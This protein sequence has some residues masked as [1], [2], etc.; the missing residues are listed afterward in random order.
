MKKIIDYFH[1]DK[2]GGFE[3][4]FAFFPILSQYNFGKVYF[5][6]IFLLI[7]DFI[8]LAK[9]RKPYMF[10]PLLL[11]LVFYIIHEIPILI[12]FGGNVFGFLQ[13]L[14]TIAS[15]FFIVP[16]LRMEKLL[17][18]IYLVAL[19]SMGGL[20]YHAAL[21]LSGN[22]G[23]LHPLTLPFLPSFDAESRA[24]EIILRPTSFY[25]EPS[26][27]IT[28]MLIPMLFSLLEKKY[29]FTFA[30]VFL[31]LLSG[32]TNGIAL[33]FLMLAFYALT[34]DV[35]LMS[36]VLVTIA[37]VAMGY[38][39]MT[40]ELFEVGVEKMNNTEIG[41][42][43]R[44]HNGIAL[45]K[46]MPLEHIITGFPANDV[47]DY[48]YK[49]QNIKIADITPL[50]TGNVFVSD[51]WGVL[52]KYGIIGLL[53]YFNIY[54]F[55]FKKD[56]A[57]RPYLL[58]LFVAMFSQCLFPGPLFAFQMMILLVYMKYGQLHEYRFLSLH[59]GAPNISSPLMQ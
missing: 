29:V 3:L 36:K 7:M 46:A 18:A 38:F 52:A 24:M 17:G 22:I 31:N 53:L 33:S 32:S 2:I 26:S 15:I 4:L 8:S 42:N 48:Y 1:L 43:Q 11:F 9:G 5:A 20:I 50:D 40:S 30:I 45:I 21:L 13:N 28:F 57:L 54:L 16:A 58:T 25:W 44:L 56:R 23:E 34:Q 35:G 51:F 47:T 14:L 49:N 41:S 37:G 55:F 39:L 19:I 12:G 27:Y 59:N 6:I 10:K